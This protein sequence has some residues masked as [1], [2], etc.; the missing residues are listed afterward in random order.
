MF[1]GEGKLCAYDYD[2][3]FVIEADYHSMLMKLFLDREAFFIQT[4][5]LI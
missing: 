1:T 4:K 3:F 5:P 2:N